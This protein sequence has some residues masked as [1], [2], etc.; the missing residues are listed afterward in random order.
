MESSGS[1][2]T[3]EQILGLQDLEREVIEPP[4][5]PGKVIVQEMTAA[6]RERFGFWAAE[7]TKD[8]QPTGKDAWKMRLTLCVMCMVDEKGDRLFKDNEIELIGE[9]SS[10]AIVAISDVAGKLSRLGP[11]VVQEAVGNSSGGQTDDSP[12]G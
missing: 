12:S 4:G 11:N 2:L 7:V 6:Q 5:W 10:T 3:R 9:R 8:G 1:V